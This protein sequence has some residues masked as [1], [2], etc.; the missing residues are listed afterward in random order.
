MLDAEIYP[1]RWPKLQTYRGGAGQSSSSDRWRG[2]GKTDGSATSAAHCYVNDEVEKDG[3]DLN[4]VVKKPEGG[5]M[6]KL[7]ADPELYG[8]IIGCDQAPFGEEVRG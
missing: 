1:C 3:K 4:V 7:A 8:F 5:R 6:A 2:A